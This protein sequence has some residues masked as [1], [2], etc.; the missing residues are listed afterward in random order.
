MNECST[1]T[2]KPVFSLRLVERTLSVEW[3]WP[4]FLYLNKG[5]LRFV[6]CLNSLSSFPFTS[7][8][9]AYRKGSYSTLRVV[10]SHFVVYCNSVTPK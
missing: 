9:S 3:L 5:Y 8:W 6:A 1:D 4:V 7:T 10:F 2:S